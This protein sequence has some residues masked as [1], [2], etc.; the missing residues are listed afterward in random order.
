[1]TTPA[2]KA[3]VRAGSTALPESGNTT[4][5]STPVD[6]MPLMSEIDFWTLP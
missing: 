5:A 6:T 2:L 1:V 4:M 3:L